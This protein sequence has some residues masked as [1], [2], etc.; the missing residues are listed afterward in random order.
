MKNL[1]NHLT[2]HPM[3]EIFAAISN[4]FWPRRTSNP[5]EACRTITP[6]HG[7]PQIHHV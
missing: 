3:S 2:I 4:D 1:I 5:P 7:K 6:F